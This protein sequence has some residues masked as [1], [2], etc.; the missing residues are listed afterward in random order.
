MKY[1]NSLIKQQED[2]PR[3]IGIKLNLVR[4]SMHLVSH[5]GIS[6]ECLSLEHMQYDLGVQVVT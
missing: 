2:H 4:N 6:Q 5:V 3:I 1:F